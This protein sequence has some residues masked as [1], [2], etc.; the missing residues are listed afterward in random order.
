MIEESQLVHLHA[1]IVQ[2]IVCLIPSHNYPTV[3]DWIWVLDF[4]SA[5]RQ[6][7]S[8]DVHPDP[9]TIIE[10]DVIQYNVSPSI[11][12]WETGDEISVW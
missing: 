12:F 6:F 9:F 11:W 4:E 1:R 7:I 2:V 8:I 3:S 5:T 10:S